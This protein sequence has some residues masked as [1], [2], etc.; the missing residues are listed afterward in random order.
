MIFNCAPI[1]QNTE[2]RQQLWQPVNNFTDVKMVV[3]VCAHILLH[4]IC[5]FTGLMR[6]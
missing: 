1:A 5:L 3:Y 4:R 2:Y 6:V